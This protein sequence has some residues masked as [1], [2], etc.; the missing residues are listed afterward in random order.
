MPLPVNFKALAAVDPTLSCEARV[1]D[2]RVGPETN[3]LL[4]DLRFDGP[5]DV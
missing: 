1:Y 3:A 5:D 2:C 4:M